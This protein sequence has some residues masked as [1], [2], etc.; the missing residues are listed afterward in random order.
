MPRTARPWWRAQRNMWCVTVAGRRIQLGP[1]PEHAPPPKYNKRKDAWNV[2]EA[3]EEAWKTMQRRRLA[4]HVL[5]HP[6]RVF[7]VDREATPGQRTAACRHPPLALRKQPADHRLVNADRLHERVQRI[8]LRI[9]RGFRRRSRSLEVRPLVKDDDV[10]PL[11]LLEE[12][13]FGGG[14]A[15]AERDDAVLEQRLD[16]PR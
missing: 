3:I 6:G 4:A 12:Q 10:C 16:A 11:L 7:G 15:A 1:H 14:L 9:R 8:V 5:G 13:F 2:P